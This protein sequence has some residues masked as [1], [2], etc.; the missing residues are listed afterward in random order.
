MTQIDRNVTK[1][2]LSFREDLGNYFQTAK[3]N[4]EVT[5][6]KL[7]RLVYLMTL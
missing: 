5:S 4:T 6:K 3:M 2:S 1:K 7:T